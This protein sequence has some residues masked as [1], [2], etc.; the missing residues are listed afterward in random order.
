MGCSINAYA[1]TVFSPASVSEDPQYPFY[2]RSP[3]LGHAQFLQQ[4]LDRRNRGFALHEIRTEPTEEVPAAAQNTGGNAPP[5]EAS[6]PS[7]LPPIKKTDLDGY[8]FSQE[9]EV[10]QKEGD[11]SNGLFNTAAGSNSVFSESSFHSQ[12]SVNEQEKSSLKHPQSVFLNDTLV[13]VV[14]SHS[15]S[16]SEGKNPRIDVALTQ[17]EFPPWDF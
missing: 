14:D 5:K 15:E 7:Y 10:S 11:P 13:I 9:E 17:E 16:P 8:C 12:L 2:S 6:Y 1:Y 3:Q 4:A